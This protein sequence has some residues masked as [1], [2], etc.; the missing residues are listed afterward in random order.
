MRRSL[1]RVLK[2]DPRGEAAA[3]LPESV[4]LQTETIDD[5]RLK[6]VDWLKIGE[7]TDAAHVLQGA[8]DTIRRLHPGVFIVVPGPVALL[9][10]GSVLKKFGYTS[11]RVET[12]LFN[13]DNFNK[14]DVDVFKGRKS[15]ALVASP[16]DSQLEVQGCERL[17]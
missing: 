13:P 10:L 12:P 4:D 16:T 17:A 5:L 11:W 9:A 8:C 3:P 1:A 2:D 15:L 6:R 7:H 14:R